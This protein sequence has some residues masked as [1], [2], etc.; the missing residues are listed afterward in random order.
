MINIYK[1][2]LDPSLLL[3]RDESSRYRHGVHLSVCLYVRLSV[4]QSV[5]LGRRAL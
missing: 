5:C 1:F 3:A 2:Y 4:R